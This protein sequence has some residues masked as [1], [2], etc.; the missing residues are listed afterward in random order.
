MSNPTVEEL[1]NET[2]YEKLYELTHATV[3]EFV[4]QQYAKEGTLPQSYAI[5]QTVMLI[6]GFIQLII[7]VVK[8]FRGEHEALLYSLA[9]IAASFSVMIPIH[10]LLHGVALKITGAPKVHYGAYPKQFLFY[11]EADHFVMNQRQF[12]LVAT[13]PL[14]IVKMI[15]L[16]AFGATFHSHIA[17]AFSMT[18]F[19]HSIFCAGDI[20]L[21]SVF[22]ESKTDRIYTYDNLQTKTSYFFRERNTEETKH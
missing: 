2:R 15:C 18:M 7:S 21:L 17:W 1:H 3:R 9:A 6:G 20:G 19:L 12:T 5:Y 10:E 13:T 16:V 11:A 8:S 4:L 22:Y 14:L